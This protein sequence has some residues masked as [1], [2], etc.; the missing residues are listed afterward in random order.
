MKIRWMNGII[1]SPNEEA[2]TR[3][4]DHR[5]SSGHELCWHHPALWGSCQEERSVP[6]F[7]MAQSGRCVKYRQ[8]LDEQVPELRVS[9]KQFQR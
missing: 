9:K 6:L 1:S 7:R 8:S 3:Y 5:D 2:K 4:R